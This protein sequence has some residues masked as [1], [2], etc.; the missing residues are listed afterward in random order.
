MSKR[1]IIIGNWKM[2]RTVSEAIRLI[3]ELKSVLS[4]KQEVEVVVAPSFVAL[5]PAEIAA[6]GTPIQIAAQDVFYEESGPYTGEISAPMLVDA[7]VKYVIVGHSE[8]RQHF[9]ETDASVNRKVKASLDNELMPVLCIGETKEQREQKKTFDV[10]ERQLR[11]CLRGVNDSYAED[12][13]VAYEPV[14]AIGTGIPATP[15]MAQEVHRF[16][17][18]KLAVIFRKDLA[19]KMRVIYGGSV[20]PQNI[21]E[22][23]AQPDINGALV[24]GASLEARTFAE[25]VNYGE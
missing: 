15:A 2:N 24:G 17:N 10:V 9:G 19:E 14:W 20:T 25:I 23:M 8:R 3:T 11:E 18:E 13:V 16:I 5:H 22:L 7:G 21:K 6:Q 12:I 4:G 1:P